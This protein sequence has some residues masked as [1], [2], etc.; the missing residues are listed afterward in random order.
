MG[1]GED[2]FAPSGDFSSP[3]ELDRR[4]RGVLENQST[5]ILYRAGRVV[6]FAWVS[7]PVFC[8]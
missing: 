4:A 5:R 1:I 2:R 6:N 7:G 3:I 8:M